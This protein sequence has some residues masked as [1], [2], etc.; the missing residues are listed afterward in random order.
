MVEIFDKLGY[1]KQTCKTCGQEFYSQVDRDTCGDAPCDEYEFIANPAT[2]K[3]YNLYEIQKVFREFLESEGH[4]HVPRYP[5][6]AKRWRD[7]VFLVGASIFCFQPWITSGLVKP[8]AN[9][10]EMAQPSIRLN[11]VDNVGRTGRHMT[12]FT[13]GTHTVINK[14]DDFIYWEDRTIE[15]CHKFFAHI[16]INTEEVTFIKS[17]W[18]GGGNEGP[19]YEVCCR[20]VELATLVFIQYETLE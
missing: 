1:K 5:V 10:I 14:E 20:G 2:D 13:M 19:C 11:D 17:W 3:P 12:C 7:D 16:G 4:T 18:A 6:L 15:L 9:P 8:P